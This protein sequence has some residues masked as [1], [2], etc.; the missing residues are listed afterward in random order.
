MAEQLLS[1]QEAAAFL[2][3]KVSE[4][5]LRALADQGGKG[6]CEVS[7]LPCPFCGGNNIVFGGGSTYRWFTVGCA[8]CDVYM[9]CGR[10]DRMQSIRENGSV[11]D[12]DKVIGAEQWNKRA[13]ANKSQP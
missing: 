10:S 2:N 4:D 3:N 13:T 1:P 9:E 7:V 8:D 5:T 11:S 12:Q 6:W